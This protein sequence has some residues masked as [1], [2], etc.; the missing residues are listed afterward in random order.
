MLY[1]PGQSFISCSNLSPLSNKYSYCPVWLCNL[2]YPSGKIHTHCLKIRAFSEWIENLHATWWHLHLT[3]YGKFSL[4]FTT[5]GPSFIITWS[6]ISNA[7]RLALQPSDSWCSSHQTLI[8]A[9]LHVSHLHTTS[10]QKQTKKPNQ[11][12]AE[13]QHCSAYKAAFLP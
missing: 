9:S 10:I 3:S 8:Q 12:N 6:Q 11:L 5:P 7:V 13:L 4:L 2:C 1:I